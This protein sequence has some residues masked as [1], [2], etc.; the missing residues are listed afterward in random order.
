M[1]VS[2]IT[3][4]WFRRDLRF[5]DNTAL[6]YALKDKYPVLPLFIFDR[7]I[8]DEL[9]NREDA[10]VSFIY[11][12]V[13]S[14]QKQLEDKG[15]TLLVRYAKPMD[16]WQ[17]LLK[18]YDI[19]QVYT[20]RDYEP[21]A[22][23][24]DQTIDK[25]LSKHDVSFMSCKDQVI[26][27]KDE[28]LTNAGDFYKVFTP[29]KRAWL[30]KLS[31]T[32]VNPLPS[33]LRFDNWY[34]TKTNGMPSLEDMNFKHSSLE[35][36]DS[37]VDE[38]LISNYD[39]SRD[40]PGLQ[41][42]TRLGIHLRFGTISIR[43]LVNQTRKLNDTFLNELIWREFYMQILH[44][45][46]QVVDKAFKPQYDNIPWRNDEEEFQRWCEGKTGYPIVDAGM[47]QLNA[48]GYMHNRVRM[49]TASF[50]TKHLLIDWRWGEAYFASK[51]LDYE[52]ANNNGGWQW[53]AGSGVDAQPYFRIF[54]P[55]SQ[56]DKF[57]KQHEYIRRWVPELDTEDYPEPM[58][59]HKEARER[60]LNIYKKAVGKN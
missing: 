3:I 28:V 23:E 8:L 6:Y 15:S 49:I 10:R 57:D 45:N 14:M 12:T 60:A 1:S 2:K 53:A 29:Y 44:H 27:E 26:Y 46:P 33:A 50:L 58:V 34:Q 41:A 48:I 35:I 4:F 38:K 24:R 39:K 32:E 25:L 7:N 43:K 36:P 51:L 17:A 13:K 56:T 31:R 42:T 37:N 16:V 30:D 55:Y 21:Y 5:E 19:A 52:L 40:Y 59:D 20:N 47:R 18:E 9:D 54:N 11:D 22:K